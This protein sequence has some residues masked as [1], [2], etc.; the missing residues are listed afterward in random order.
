[1]TEEIL[2]DKQELLLAIFVSK[3]F[4]SSTLYLI[5]SR[6]NVSTFDFHMDLINYILSEKNFFFTLYNDEYTSEKFLDKTAALFTG[7]INSSSFE[8]YLDKL[9]IANKKIIK[10]DLAQKIKIKNNAFNLD[11]FENF[12]KS[13]E[14]VLSKN[15]ME[16]RINHSTYDYKLDQF[17][18]IRN[19]LKKYSSLIEIGFLFLG[20]LGYNMETLNKLSINEGKSWID[21]INAKIKNNYIEEK[22]EDKNEFF[23]FNQAALSRKEVYCIIKKDN[24]ENYY[25]NIN[26]KFSKKLSEAIFFE[27]NKAT[28]YLKK[29]ENNQGLLIAKLEINGTSN[30]KNNQIINEPK[31]SFGDKISLAIKAGTLMFLGRFDEMEAILKKY[32]IEKKDIV[33]IDSQRKSLKE[34]LNKEEILLLENIFPKIDYIWQFKERLPTQTIIE[35][36]YIHSVMLPNLCKIYK[37]CF[38]IQINK[39]FYSYR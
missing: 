35:V 9:K 6:I 15:L 18:M 14:E 37:A 29:L 13:K 3:K 31:L 19:Y 8:Y 36:N 17:K 2:I 12:L 1:M 25:L 27:K 39:H 30:I 20:N 10:K 21:L 34:N 24:N 23:T 33:N 38:I 32:K 26:Q 4:Y 28:E 11:A 5:D 7:Q 22:T 16:G